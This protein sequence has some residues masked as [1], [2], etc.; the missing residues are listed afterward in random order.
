MRISDWSSDVCSS[1][2]TIRGYADSYGARLTEWYEDDRIII[3]PFWPLNIDLDFLQTLSLP[4]TYKKLGSANR[5]DAPLL[6]RTPDGRFVG[7]NLLLELPFYITP[8]TYRHEQ[9]RALSRYLA[10]TLPFLF[11]PSSN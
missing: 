11:P 5:I 7:N 1:D 8:Q 6:K 4:E 9:L 10:K 2:L 3:L